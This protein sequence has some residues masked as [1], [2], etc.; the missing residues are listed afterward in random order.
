MLK[1]LYTKNL[2]FN[3]GIL[4]VLFTMIFKKAIE[5][6]GSIIF[7]YYC[8]LCNIQEC[9]NYG[10]CIECWKKLIFIN[11][12][13]CYVC[14]RMLELN[15]ENKITCLKCIMHKNHFDH[16]RSLFYFNDA[17]QQLIHHIKYYDKTY[18]LKL[19][20]KLVAVNYKD[21]YSVCDLIIPVPMHKSKRLK[22]LYNQAQVIGSYI[23]Q[24]LGIPIRNDILL[25]H[26][27]TIAQSDLTAKQRK[28]NLKNCF[29]VHQK[30]RIKNKNILLIDDVMTT[31]TTIN[32]CSEM[33]KKHGADQVLCFTIAST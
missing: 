1:I 14:G 30:F 3:Y 15:L 4:T 7:P 9:D 17:S 5:I 24:S 8:V 20:S 11:P 6:L 27:T 29:T 28:N 22:R 33:L 16:A 18:S 23:S 13:F 19:L 21:F 12:P 10:F 25:K 26:K 32:R 31:G 2:I